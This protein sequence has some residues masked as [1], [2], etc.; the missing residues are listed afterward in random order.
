MPAWGPGSSPVWGAGPAP[1]PV[2]VPGPRSLPPPPVPVPGRGARAPALCPGKGQLLLHC[3]LPK[4][5]PQ[6]IPAP[7]RKPRD[8]PSHTS[9]TVL[10]S[11]TPL[12][13]PRSERAAGNNLHLEQ[14]ESSRGEITQGE[15]ARRGDG[16]Q[17]LRKVERGGR[18]S[19]RGEGE[20]NIRMGRGRKRKRGR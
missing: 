7:E 18:R 2:P 9:R 17:N 5:N 14:G 10:G 16:P 11:G 13:T 6:K 3:P 19:G 8:N 12:G 1:P 20:E 4:G 15:S